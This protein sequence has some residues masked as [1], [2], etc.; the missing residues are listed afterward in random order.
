MNELMVVVVVVYI[1]MYV[2]V[3]MYVCLRA[4]MAALTYS[5]VVLRTCDVQSHADGH[6]YLHH[7]TKCKTKQ[8][9]RRVRL[10]FSRCAISWGLE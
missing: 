4:A 10:H 8:V 9:N 1:Y 2:Y 7:I 5:T 6:A 3:C